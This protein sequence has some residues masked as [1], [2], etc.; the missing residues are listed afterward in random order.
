MASELRAGVAQG[1]EPLVDVG[2]R[3]VLAEVDRL[4]ALERSCGVLDTEL[5]A[6]PGVC[7][8][9]P[10]VETPDTMAWR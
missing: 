10:A 2:E 1:R 7:A 3:L 9:L 5:A 8:G 4:R 6:V